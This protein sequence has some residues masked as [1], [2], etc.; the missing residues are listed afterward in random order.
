MLGV[1]YTV[2]S[3]ATG[4]L[5]P[6]GSWPTDTV[7]VRYRHRSSVVTPGHGR[8]INASGVSDSNGAVSVFIELEADLT[9][10]LVGVEV[11]S[12]AFA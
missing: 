9:D 4:T 7:S 8:L 11:D 5:A 6:V 3:Y 1:D 2:S 12:E 10:E